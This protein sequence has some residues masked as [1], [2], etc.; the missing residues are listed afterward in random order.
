MPAAHVEVKGLDELAKKI[1]S[2]TSLRAFNDGLK[3]GA[4][5]I[6]A[7]VKQYPPSSAANIDPGTSPGSWY[8]RKKGTWYR[9]VAGMTKNYGKSERLGTQ[10]NLHQLT[11]RALTWIIS[12][13]V[14]YGRFVQSEDDQAH[15]H[16]K[17]GWKTIETIARIHAKD[18]LKYV[19]QNVDMALEK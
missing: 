9:N 8:E 13:S 5:H 16:R 15:F 14:S 11:G 7:K 2:I 18:V 17:R 6:M 1:D 3:K 12:N 4:T 19:K 10:W